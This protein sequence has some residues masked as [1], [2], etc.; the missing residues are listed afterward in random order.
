MNVRRLSGRLPA[1]T[2]AV[3]AFQAVKDQGRE[4]GDDTKDKKRFV[5]PSHHD[6]GIC[7]KT[8]GDEKGGCQPRRRNAEADGH[9]LRRA[10]DGAGVARVGLIDVGVYEGVHA[11][12]L[13][14]LEASIAEGLQRD[15]PDGRG[16]SDG[17]KTA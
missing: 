12:V 8:V 4:D 14:R 3:A 5:E 9:L 10:G 1:H 7:V 17:R 16:G 13:Q 11:R 6:V 15:D 2:G